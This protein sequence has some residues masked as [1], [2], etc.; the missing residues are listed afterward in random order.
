VSSSGVTSTYN[1]GDCDWGGCSGH[2]VTLQLRHTSD[3]FTYKDERGTETVFGM[4]EMRNLIAMATGLL[5][6]DE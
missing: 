6:D 5:G 2:E 4:A 3:T 1:C